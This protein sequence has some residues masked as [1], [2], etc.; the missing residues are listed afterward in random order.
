MTA[1]HVPWMHVHMSENIPS[2]ELYKYLIQH[3]CYCAAVGV[4]QQCSQEYWDEDLDSGA[5]RTTQIHKL[6]TDQRAYLSTNN[7]E[8]ERNL[9][10]FGYLASMSAKRSNKYF[11]A[12]R[13]RD[14]MMFSKDSDRKEVNRKALKIMNKLDEME[15]VWVEEQ[16]EEK[17]KVL[18]HK[19]KKKHNA[20][21]FL[22]SVLEKCKQHGGP[23]TSP[24]D[25]TLIRENKSF[26]RLEIQ[27]RRI[28]NPKDAVARKDLYKLFMG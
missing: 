11:K 13:I 4:K 14:G 7:I 20:N 8:A 17:L 28:T 19:L 2:T 5:I 3:M 23:L 15:M 9:G 24:D 27:F 21:A 25:I 22:D 1:Y 26:L 12:K 18:E 10:K 6:S 16:K